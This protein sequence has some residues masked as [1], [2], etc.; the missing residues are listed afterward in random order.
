MQKT[1]FYTIPNIK[2][3][4]EKKD[5]YELVWVLGMHSMYIYTMY[6]VLSHLAHIMIMY[7][8]A[9]IWIALKSVDNEIHPLL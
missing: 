1:Q 8:G 2:C 3:V 9:L 6:D 7:Y 4:K 5:R